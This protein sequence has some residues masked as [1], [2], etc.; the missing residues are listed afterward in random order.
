MITKSSGSLSF[1]GNRWIQTNIK[2]NVHIFPCFPYIHHP[3]K[4]TKYIVHTFPCFPYLH[5]LTESNRYYD[6]GSIWCS[7]SIT[8]LTLVTSWTKESS[9]WGWNLQMYF[10]QFKN[11]TVNYSN[12]TNHRIY[13]K[14]VPINVTPKIKSDWYLGS[15]IFCDM[16]YWHISN[17]IVSWIKNYVQ[18]FSGN[19]YTSHR[20]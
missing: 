16:F 4:S 2:Y 14:A 7:P 15:L 10:L 3:T 12:E 5:Y 9:F 6:S 1:T 17:A 19:S 20:K 8:L 11:D 13:T 18:C